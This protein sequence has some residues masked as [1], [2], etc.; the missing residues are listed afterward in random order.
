VTRLINF[1][2]LLFGL[3]TTGL[4]IAAYLEKKH[5]MSLV[6]GVGIGILT[7]ASIFLW[8][9]KP[10]A[11]RILSGVCA[12]AILGMFGGR[13][14]SKP[15]DFAWYPAGIEIAASAFT[16]VVLAAGHFMANKKG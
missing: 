4:G 13:T 11:G 3:L 1:T 12:L 9:S 5:V 16:L 15:E 8:M 2:V 7:I 14:L 6:G 10:R